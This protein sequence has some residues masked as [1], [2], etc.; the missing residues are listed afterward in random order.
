M[1]LRARLLPCLALGAALSL[2]A[3]E[4]EPLRGQT[5][6]PGRAGR[7]PRLMSRLYHFR[8]ARIQQIVGLPEDRARLVAERWSRWDR[9]HLERGQQAVELRRQFNQILMGPEREEDKNARLRPLIDQFIVLR[10]QQ[11]AGRK[12]FEEDVRAGLTPAQQ[13]RLILAMDEI[14]QR[15]REVLREGVGRGEH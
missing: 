2:Q 15:L 12:Q 6:R 4:A 9:E 13:A 5:P 3:R 7:D 1:S 10:Q 14:Q 8:L 11:E